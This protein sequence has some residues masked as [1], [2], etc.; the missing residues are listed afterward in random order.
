MRTKACVTAMLMALA[1]RPHAALA[2]EVE[3]APYYGYRF[4]GDFFELIAGRPVDTDGTPA[5]G[6]AVN[7]PLKDG[8]QLEGLFTHQSGAGHITVDHWLGG[9]LQ[10][11]GGSRVRPFTTG[12]LG[13]TRYA[14]DADQ[15]LRFTLA[16][17]GGIKAFPVRWL[18]L[19]L[20]GRLFATFIDVDSRFTACSSER[21]CVIALHAD[22]VWQAEFTAGVTVRLP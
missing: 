13:L 16:A 22:I 9:G 15:E 5:V 11:F 14:L 12:M 6:F 8:L 3:A 1:G 18:G 17:G 20:D 4:G 2:Q 19:R 7:V 21:G 10:E